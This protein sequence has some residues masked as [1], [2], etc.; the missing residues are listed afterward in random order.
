VRHQ[1]EDAVADDQSSV[2]ELHAALTRRPKELGEK[3]SRLIDLA[4][5]AA[6][7]QA[8]VRA[9]LPEIQRDRERA[10]AELANT[11]EELAVGAAVLRDA[12][13]CRT[14][15]ALLQRSVVVASL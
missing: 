3:E 2:R 6:L 13:C 8:K 4:A 7:P 5:D 10:Q 12:P 1:L 9:K 15:A 11:G 14:T